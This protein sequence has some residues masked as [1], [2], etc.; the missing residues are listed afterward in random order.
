MSKPPVLNL[1]KIHKSFKQGKEKLTVLDNASLDI[2]EGEIVGLVGPS[3]CGK[4]TLLQI[5]GL[6]DHPDSGEVSINGHDCSNTSDNQQTKLRRN[7]LG[8]VYQFHHLLPDFT[9]QENVIIPQLINQVKEKDAI[10]H[11][12]EILSYLGLE[13]RLDHRPAELSGG[14]QQRVAIARAL[15]T[16][17]LILLADE[18]TGNLDPHTAEEVF[19]LLIKTAKGIGLALLIVTHNHELTKDM[20]RVVT[21]ED[22]KIKKEKS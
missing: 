2:K 22:G 1:K 5:A 17:P 12:K 6:L 19:N 7:S 21:I 11:A 18:P 10:D 15:V 14:E 16:K 8:F 9:A 20:D 13:K 4:S 3:G